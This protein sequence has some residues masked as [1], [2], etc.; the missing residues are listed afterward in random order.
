MAVKVG[1]KF[2]EIWN[3]SLEWAVTEYEK[4]QVEKGQIVFYGPSNFTRWSSRYGMRPLRNE[5]K[6]ASGKECIVNRG[7]GSSCSEHQLYYYPRMIR[8]L[9]PAVLVY[10]FYG[11]GEDFGYSAEEKWELAQRVIVYAMTD[12]PEAELYLCSASPSPTELNFCQRGE[13]ERFNSWVKLF[14]ESHPRCHYVDIFNYAPLSDPELYVEDMVH[15]NQK[16]YDL[17]AEFFKDVL[18]DEL[19]KY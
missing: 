10:S 4:E 19:K 8:P 1:L 15:F 13:A 14:A 16:G 5:I 17:Y 6:G 7:F 11:N 3:D 18:A 12:F 9:E 2:I